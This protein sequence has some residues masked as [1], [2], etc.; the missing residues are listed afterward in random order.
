MAISGVPLYRYATRAYAR[1]RWDL[2]RIRNVASGDAGD[3]IDPVND[4]ERR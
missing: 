1:Q 2:R 4:L 3:R